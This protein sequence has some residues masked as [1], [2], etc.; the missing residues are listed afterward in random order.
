MKN[1]RYT[2]VNQEKKWKIP[3]NGTKIWC[4]KMH[5]VLFGLPIPYSG[6]RNPYFGYPGVT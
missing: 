3:V 4:D 6:I 1:F 5:S 2:S